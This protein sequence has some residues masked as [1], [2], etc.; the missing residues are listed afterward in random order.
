MVSTAIKNITF[1]ITGATAAYVGTEL[2]WPLGSTNVTQSSDLTGRWRMERVEDMSQISTDA[3]YVVAGTNTK[4]HVGK[5]SDERN[6][7]WEPYT[8]SNAGIINDIDKWSVFHLKNLS[9]YSSVYVPS[10]DTNVFLTEEQK[11]EFYILFDDYMNKFLCEGITYGP[12]SLIFS[13]DFWAAL[14]PRA[15]TNNT[16]AFKGWFFDPAGQPPHNIIWCDN[17]PSVPIPDGGRHYR[18]ILPSY[19]EVGYEPW[20]GWPYRNAPDPQESFRT[21]AMTLYK[22]TRVE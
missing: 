16:V 7:W 18:E 6:N 22:I 12:N 20:T 15:I 11:A 3:Y 2:F 21:R 13:D 5:C 17:R 19:Y 9:E 10:G 14:N 1:G 4:I 8:Y